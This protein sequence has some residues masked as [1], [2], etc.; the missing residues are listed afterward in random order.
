[1]ITAHVHKEC[2]QKTWLDR[3]HYLPGTSLKRSRIQLE[4]DGG[5]R[6]IQF[7]ALGY[8][9]ICFAFFGQFVADDSTSENNQGGNNDS[10]NESV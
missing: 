1:M 5:R 7:V 6:L 9:A 3:T 2:V 8:E 4:H 10:V